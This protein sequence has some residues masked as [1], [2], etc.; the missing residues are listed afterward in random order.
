[1]SQQSVMLISESFS[2][3]DPLKPSKTKQPLSNHFPGNVLGNL[4]RN[5]SFSPE[6]QSSE[7]LTEECSLNYEANFYP[8][9]SNS[10]TSKNHNNYYL[11]HVASKNSDNHVNN[12]NQNYNY[13]NNNVNQKYNKN[14]NSYP[15]TSTNNNNSPMGPSVPGNNSEVMNVMIM[16]QQ[17]SAHVTSLAPQHPP[18][19]P[20]FPSKNS[21]FSGVASVHASGHLSLSN[22]DPNSAN[23]SRHNSSASSNLSDTTPSP[24]PAESLDNQGSNQEFNKHFQKFHNRAQNEK[25]NKIESKRF[26]ENKDEMGGK[27]DDVE[28]RGLSEI[29]LEVGKSILNISKLNQGMPRKDLAWPAQRHAQSRARYSPYVEKDEKATDIT[30]INVGKNAGIEKENLIINDNVKI[31]IGCIDA[32][33]VI[34]NLNTSNR[35]SSLTDINDADTNI[36]NER[37]GC[38][39]Y[40][41]YL[42]NRIAKRYKRNKATFFVAL[43]RQFR[44]FNRSIG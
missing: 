24:L 21:A 31:E 33:T 43:T 1:M 34:T 22:A 30:E 14:K 13:Y 20:I 39:G 4:Q 18:L 3:T 41:L 44:V 2:S 17:N 40:I 5:L 35:C 28:K 29:D 26:V 42:R 11:N 6:V 9:L 12:P 7:K 27:V 38:Y 16:D 32:D 19:Y 37:R 15:T 10:V 8:N 23:N 36:E 25:L